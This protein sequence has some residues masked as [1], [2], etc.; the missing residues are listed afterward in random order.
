MWK[1]EIATDP[2]TWNLPLWK[3]DD[4]PATE[5]TGWMNAVDMTNSKDGKTIDEIYIQPRAVF[6]PPCVMRITCKFP[7]SVPA[8]ASLIFG[9]EV[10]SQGGQAIYQVLMDSTGFHLKSNCITPTANPDPQDAAITLTDQ[11]NYHNLWL[12]YDPPKLY[13]WGWNGSATAL[14]GTVTIGHSP[15]AYDCVSPF[16]TNESSSIVSGFCV[17]HW[18]VWQKSH[19]AETIL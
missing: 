13:L 11:T 16:V 7:A 19:V 18:A 10:N 4:A 12:Y 3:P 14:L 2:S 17:G 15:D 1:S 6:D 5:G 9:F 8:G